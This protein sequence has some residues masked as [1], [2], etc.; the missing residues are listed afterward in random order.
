MTLCRTSH[1][2]VWVMGDNILNYFLL[3]HWNL[4]RRP[5]SHSGRI[6]L[7]RSIEHLTIS[8][9]GIVSNVTRLQ[10]WMVGTSSEVTMSADELTKRPRFLSPD[11]TV[12]PSRSATRSRARCRKSA[13]PLVSAA[14]KGFC[15]TKRC[16]IL[17]SI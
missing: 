10:G 13:E 14:V 11:W 1:F 12:S 9:A 5:L 7:N 16:A 3:L 15:E 8:C 4:M 2:L 17:F 6:H